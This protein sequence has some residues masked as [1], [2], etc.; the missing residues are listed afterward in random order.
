MTPG[1]RSGLSSV[2]ATATRGARDCTPSM[3][4]RASRELADVRRAYVDPALGSLLTL[5]RGVELIEEAAAP[6]DAAIVV[7][8]AVS[9][10]GSL[11][12][13]QGSVGA[14]RVI[15]L[16]PSTERSGI[17]ARLEGADAGARAHRVITADAVIDVTDEGFVVREVRLGVSAADVQRAADARLFASPDLSIYD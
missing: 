9:A 15:V 17:S 4:R 7:G 10:G 3:L 14:A 12:W 8:Q 11:Q 13:E 5:P 2:D 1:L 16:L 6:A